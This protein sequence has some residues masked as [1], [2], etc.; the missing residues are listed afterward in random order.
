MAALKTA[1]KRSSVVFLAAD[2]EVGGP[3]LGKIQLTIHQRRAEVI[4]GVSFFNVFGF[5]SLDVLIQF[6]PFLF[7]AEITAMF[8][9]RSG[10]DVLFGIRVSGTLKGPTPWNVHG[11]ASFEIGF[12]IK[13]RLSANFDVTSGE[14]RN[15]LLPTIDVIGEIS[16]AINN[17]G[18]W[19]AVLPPGSNQHVS[20][21]AL[22]DAG[23]ALVLHPFGALEI[24]Q[25][26]V[27]LD[28]AIQRFGSSR[29]DRGSVFK[30]DSESFFGTS[31]GG[32][33]LHRRHT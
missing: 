9:V 1:R 22:P 29:P 30:I 13:V 24:S 18:N 15:T 33:E 28:I 21:R 16:K 4:Y 7:I 31:P 12:I 17:V 23:D 10:S 27:P 19:R 25:K 5:V 11:E 8:G 2:A 32:A 6:N 20:L 3:L 26:I 14:S